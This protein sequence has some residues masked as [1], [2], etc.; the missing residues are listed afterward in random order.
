[1]VPERHVSNGSDIALQVCMNLYRII[2]S[3][4][5][6]SHIRRAGRRVAF[7]EVSDFW[8]VDYSLD[9]RSKRIVNVLGRRTDSSEGE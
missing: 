5:R 4:A 3:T 8:D 1:M 7:N 9:L 2:H 6:H